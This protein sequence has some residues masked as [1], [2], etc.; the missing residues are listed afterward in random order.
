MD[1]FSLGGMSWSVEERQAWLFPPASGEAIGI[2]LAYMDPADPDDRH[3][4]IRAQHPEFD[5][6]LE[7][8]VEEI[9]VEGQPMSPRMHIT[10]HEVAANQIWDGEPEMTWRTAERLTGLG[11]EHHEVLHMVASVVST[12]IFE[13]LQGR[14]TDPD[15]ME[16]GFAALPESWEAARAGPD[17][18]GRRS[19]RRR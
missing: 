2:D 5:Q 3:L 17:H 8:G 18:R 4:L 6:A 19:R 10:M 16:Q 14:E 1:P 12:E 9:E 11:Y 15:R 7:E 13:A